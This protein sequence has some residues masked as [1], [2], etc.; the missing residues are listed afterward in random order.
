[1][2]RPI[3]L[4]VVNRNRPLDYT[5][6]SPPNQ[7]EKLAE[8]VG[9]LY[10]LPAVA[11][12]VLELTNQPKVD[13]RAIKHCIEKDP[14]LVSKILRVVNSSLFG[15]SRQVSDLNQALALLGIKPLK[16]LVLG[17]SLSDGR[18]SA[19]TNTAADHY[20]RFA[21]TQAVAAREL[22]EQHWNKPGDEPF[23]TALLADL[24][25]LLLLQELSGPYGQL[26]RKAAAARRDLASLE[27][28]SLGFEHVALTVRMLEI[29]K[30]P[31]AMVTAIRQSTSPDQ[32]GSLLPRDRLLPEIIYLARMIADLLVNGR[33]ET[34]RELIGYGNERHGLTQDALSR[35]VGGVQEKIT[36]LAELFSLKFPPGL[37]YRDV[38]CQAHAQLARAAEET[39][40]SLLN[41]RATFSADE[42]ETDRDAHQLLSETQT[43]ARAAAELAHSPRPTAT[44]NP[45]V[46]RA[47]RG[48]KATDVDLEPNSH[49][50]RVT[51]P[52]AALRTFAQDATVEKRLGKQAA[53]P[54][55]G[56]EASHSAA[57]SRDTALAEPPLPT[58]VGQVV[59]L[60][61]AN[62]WSLSLLLVELSGGDE[63]IAAVGPVAAQ[64]YL[65][66]VREACQA[67][68]VDHGRVAQTKE[69]QFAIVLAD[70]ERGRAVRIGYDLM[71][72]IEDL[73]AAT[74]MSPS[75]GVS[76]VALPPKNFRASDLI[77]SAGRCLS[78][79]LLG[80]GGVLK[81]IEIY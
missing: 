32:F 30:F 58:V 8:R 45:S 5:P 63:L 19:N 21:L 23:I 78:A 51:R 13:I 64:H 75:V 57:A 10:S 1:M 54:V 52:T 43:L 2:N 47:P 40:A 72:T 65:R 48:G 16:L 6:M 39:A 73:A 36:P 12:E 55:R 3:G 37:D 76:S 71:Q 11:I 60:C 79:A 34:L 18:F 4:A 70:C 53:K 14:A 33:Y 74:P 17:F 29:W 69:W 68:D 24:G 77:E 50:E 56:Q 67:A 35:L 7:L 81:S 31:P 44:S 46:A 80:G 41:P 25:M 59:A 61:R 38:L 42:H 49:G 66:Q 27:L 9:Q 62:R 28:E 20:W 22:A 26:V 15:L